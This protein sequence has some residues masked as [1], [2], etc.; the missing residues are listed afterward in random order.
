MKN[1]PISIQTFSDLITQDYLYI[2]KTKEIYNLFARGG[3]YYFL[4]RPR[5][6]GK[7]L[8]ISTLKEIFSGNKE[9]F[10][11]LWIYDKIQWQ[12]FP[13]IH[14][15]FTRISFQTPKIL[16]KELNLKL[17]KIAGTYHIKLDR[18]RDFKGKFADLIE[19][20]AEKER[21]VILIDEYDK[22]I[23]EFIET[24][25]K[26][27]AQ[28]NRKVLKNFYSILKSADEY[29]R[30]VFITGVSKF[31]RMSIFSDLNNL[32][33]ITIDDNFS[34]ILGLTHDELH[35]Y[36]ADHIDHLSKKLNMSESD[37]LGHV[38]QWYNGYSWDGCHFL[39]NPFS[40]LNFF[41]KNRFGNYWFATGTPT[42]LINH[43][44]NRKQ[45]VT[46]LEKQEVDE[47]IF[48][49]YDIENLEVVSML[50]QTGYLTIKEIR[51]VGLKSQYVLSYPNQEVKESFLKHFLADYTT[52][53]TGLVG[54]K[55]LDLVK[56]I[57]TDDPENFF[58]IIKSL[59][60]SIPSSLFIRDR[61]A[62]YHTIIY[63]VLEL[64]GVNIQVEVHTNKGRID[65]VIETAD[66]I[67]IME[68]KMGTS[69]EALS[70]I[71]GRKY[72]ERGKK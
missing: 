56:A 67:Y 19:K 44:R 18:Q 10:K 62:Y 47:S 53:E 35:T 9:L 49:S 15:D 58:T 24:G 48:E 29:T 54:S 5:R 23:I 66:H 39:Y 65:A 30:F 71:E 50:F 14:I 11:G 32:N 37:F 22:P 41:S 55:I 70:Q 69:A 64:L 61:E 34:S 51:L 38:K 59:F 3:K 21:V 7:S 36:F 27:I 4:S 20:M 63:L 25:D 52:E 43:I 57:T 16:E 1:L 13:V 12:S 45:D 68:F 17:E 6:F 31:S 26:K 28:A 8:L 60:A 72:H 42:F 46:T 33:D 40:I 2:D